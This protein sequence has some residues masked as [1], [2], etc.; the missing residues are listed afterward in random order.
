MSI[1][2]PGGF[3]FSCKIFWTLDAS[4]YQ[5]CGFCFRLIFLAKLSKICCS[6][7]RYVILVCHAWSTTHFCHPS[8]LLER[9]EFEKIVCYC[10]AYFLG[11]C[12][13]LHVSCLP[14][15]YSTLTWFFVNMLALMD[16]SWSSP[17][18]T[19]KWEVSCFQ[20]KIKVFMDTNCHFL[21]YSCN[22][23][24]SVISC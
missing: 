24:L 8:Q 23:C 7:Y 13:S 10:G 2:W 5:L 9:W 12:C 19:L 1:Q 17:Q 14:F 6:F 20:L 4:I 16:G 3:L 11:T 22:K 21:S 18:W 15:P